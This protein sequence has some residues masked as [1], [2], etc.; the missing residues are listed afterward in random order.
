MFYVFSYARV[1]ALI[2]NKADRFAQQ[3]M[4]D[5]FICFCYTIYIRN[6]MVRFNYNK[7]TS[8]L[9]LILKRN[10][11]RIDISVFFCYT[12]KVVGIALL[13]NINHFQFYTRCFQAVESSLNIRKGKQMSDRAGKPT[14]NPITQF[15]LYLCFLS[16]T[17]L[18]N[19]EVIKRLDNLLKVLLQYKGS[20]KR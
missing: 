1:R 8:F 5:S 16:K 14:Q 19:Q 10:K 3:K 2:S 7:C 9:S 12:I 4:F 11:K 20:K 15:C 18:N 6:E 17:S 13:I